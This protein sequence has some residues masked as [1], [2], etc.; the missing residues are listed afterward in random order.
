MKANKTDFSNYHPI[1]LTSTCVN[2]VEK[3]ISKQLLIRFLL[4]SNAIPHKQHR[5]SP[6]G[7]YHL[8]QAILDGVYLYFAKAFDQV[9]HG[10]IFA[11]VDGRRRCS[12]IAGILDQGISKILFLQYI[13]DLNPAVGS[14]FFGEM[15]LVVLY[16]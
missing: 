5:I 2:F 15:V 4:Q 3:T 1:S 7:N 9:P 13:A 12:Q 8:P 11:K 16:H 14:R 10:R 6:T